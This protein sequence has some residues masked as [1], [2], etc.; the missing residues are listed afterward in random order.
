M[1]FHSQGWMTTL[2]HPSVVFGLPVLWVFGVYSLASYMTTRR[3]LHVR[4]AMQVYNLAQIILCSYMVWG[5]FPCVMHNFFGINSTHDAAGEWFVFV[6]Y[7]SK[8]MD[9]FDTLWILAKKNRQQLSFLHVYH[10]STISMVWGY[11]LWSNVGNGTIR[12]GAW[13]NSLT[14]VIMYSHYLWTSFGL[15]N[16]FKRYITMWQISQFYSCLAHALTVRSLETTVAW[17]YAWLQ[18]CYQ[19]TMVYLFTL[20]MS[21]VPSCT[22]E[23]SA[24]I[25]DPGA[26]VS[27]TK[28]YIIIRGETYDVTSF[29][30]PGGGHMLDLA[31]GRDATLMFESAH[32]R[33]KPEKVLKSLPKGPSLENLEKAGYTFDRPQEHW[34]T[35]GQSELYQTMRK[36]ICEEILKPEGRLDDPDGARGVPLWHIGSVILTWLIT[37]TLFVVYPSLLTGIIL[38]L[39]LC[40]IGL[41]IQHTANHGGLVKDPH[42]GYWL[43]LLNDVGPGGSS[44]VWRYHHQVS[45]HAYCNDVVLDQ[46]AHSSYPIL[47]LDKSQQLQPWHKYQCVYGLLL[48][49]QLWASIHWQ[50]LQCLLDARTFM[51]RFKGTSAPEIVL[52]LGLKL[53]HIAWFYVLP[54]CLHGARAMIV[55][56]CAALMCGSFWLAALFIVSHNLLPCKHREAPAMASGDWARYQIETSSSWGGA[57]GSFLTGGLNLQIEHHLF[58]CMAHHLYARVQPIVEEECQTAG[59]EYTRYDYFLPNLMDHVRFL[60]SFGQPSLPSGKVEGKKVK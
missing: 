30:H 55:P 28:R 48:F 56:W 54:A 41:A 59:V 49:T 33:D 57:I 10:H 11:L 14:H 9:W 18:I 36:R 43:G 46:D 23:L 16:P 25:P 52:G 31:I 19:I 42:V 40:W 17:E 44:L 24:K 13:V 29:D 32:I 27:A 45:H 58:P 51:V 5:M 22:P 1:K 60:Y 15:K 39:S 37:G 47:R 38:G 20:R 53:V 12:Y 3:P 35:P 6:H 26:D 2:V 21:Y 34:A 7:L 8:Y 50:D 4:R